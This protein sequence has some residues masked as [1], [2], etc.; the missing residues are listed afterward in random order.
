MNVKSPQLSQVPSGQHHHTRLFTSTS[1][2]AASDHLRRVFHDIDSCPRSPIHPVLSIWL[3][4][5]RNRQLN[6]KHDSDGRSAMPGSRR[7]D[8]IV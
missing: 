7:R 3:T 5:L 8:Q 6:G 1:T 4:R 2:P